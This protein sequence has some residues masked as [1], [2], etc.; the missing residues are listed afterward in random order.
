MT[1][2]SMALLAFD[3]TI[4]WFL[5][6]LQPHLLVSP[7]TLLHEVANGIS[8]VRRGAQSTNQ[9][10]RGDRWHQGR[11]LT[12]YSICPI[13]KDICRCKRPKGRVDQ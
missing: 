9:L 5:M 11:R 8:I 4:L 6:A 7:M 13:E 2:T 3:K 10:S 1:G 12:L